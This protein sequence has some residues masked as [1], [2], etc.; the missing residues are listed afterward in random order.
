MSA[1]SNWE[2]PGERLAVDHGLDTELD[3]GDFGDAV[4]VVIVAGFEVDGEP[5]GA[6]ESRGG[7]DEEGREGSEEHGVL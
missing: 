5:G 2:K 3:L 4:L 6:S 7:E 1:D